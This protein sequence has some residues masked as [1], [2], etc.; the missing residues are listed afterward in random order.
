MRAIAI[1]VLVIGV[2]S[3]VGCGPMGTSPMPPRLEAD[4][5]K[6]IDD[7][8]EKAVNPHDQLDRQAIL[9]SLILTQAYQVGVDRL[10][11]RSEKAYSRGIVI[12]EIHYDR[13]KPNEDRFEITIQD[14]DG[15]PLRELT[16]NRSE[17]EL[18]SKEL[19]D[20]RFAAPRGPNDPP[21][22]PEDE[23]KRAEI[24]KRKAVVEAIF[25]KADEGK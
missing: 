13:A 14:N 2:I 15:K 8:W 22:G 21:L 5:Q 11:F 9:D 3:L 20:P 6:N 25:P 1:S 19:I 7:S 17:I 18:A 4:Q 12:M 10:H 23:K 16:Y 24:Q